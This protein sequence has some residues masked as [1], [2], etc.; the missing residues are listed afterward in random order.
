[1]VPVP[2][3]II[4]QIK[5]NLYGTGWTVRLTL[6]IN[7]MNQITP[8]KA[9]K[10]AFRKVKP[11][12]EA[13]EDFKK[14]LLECIEDI[15]EAESEEFHKTLVRD[16]LKNTYY[17][18]YFMNTKGRNDQVIHE[19]KSESTPVAVI[20][21]TKRPTNKS[22]MVSKD[23]L[24]AKAMQELLLYYL[25]E[26]IKHKNEHIK[27]LVI[28]N[29]YEWFIFD[30][31]VFDKYFYKN[32]KLLDD[33]KDFD[34]E[35]MSG[36]GTDYF[37]NNIAKPVIEDVKNGLEFTY[38]DIRD[39]RKL[40]KTEDSQD[41]AKLIP[42][43]KIFSPEHLLKLPFSNDSN[44][45]DRNFYEELLHIIGLKETKQ[46]SK[47]LIQRFP[48][49]E[50]N[51]GSLLEN[52]ITKL[53]NRDHLSQVENLPSYGSTREEQLFAV[54]LE[55][56]ITWIN[57][58]LFLK[59]LEAQLLSYHKQDP[60][61]KF[62]NIDRIS[63]YDELDNLFFAVLAKKHEER[64]DKNKRDFSHIPYLNS[65]LFE[66]AP[67][68]HKTIFV[69]DLRDD[70]TLPIISKTVFKTDK[71][72]KLKGELNVI[73]YLF[74]FLDAYDFSS[75]GAEDIQEE[76][77][78][79]INA[80]VLGLIFEKINGYKDGSYF[81]P[82]FIT[83][84]M[85]RETIRRAVVQKFNEAKDW[86]CK[87]INDIYDKIDDRKEANEIVNSL[88][89]CDPAVGSGHFL[90]SALNEILAIKHELKI[91]SDREGK[92]L[93]EYTVS[94]ENDE[95]IIMDDDD[96]LFEYNPKLPESQR[97]QETLFHEK[98]TI[99]ENCLFGVDI[100]PNSV[101]ICRLRLWIELLKNAYYKNETELE[102]LPNIDINIKCGNSL[103]S[104]F[105]IKADL[106]K[107]LKKSKFD[108][109][110]YRDAVHVYQNA[111]DKVQKR[112]MQDLINEIKSN[113]RT[114][115]YANDPKIKRM[116]KLQGEIFNLTNQQ[117]IFE[118]S[119]KE[120]TA[121]E[122]NITQLTADSRKLEA[123]IDE[124]KNN[125]IYENAFE[126]RFEFPEV[127]DNNGDFIG[128]DVIIGNPPYVD[129][130]S[131]DNNFVKF[132]FKDYTT[133]ENR[134][135]LYSLF[136]ELGYNI[137][138]HAGQFCFINPNSILMNSSYKKIRQLISPN[139]IEIIKLPDNIFAASSVKVE[140]I[141]LS[142]IKNEILKYAN[143][144]RYPHDTTITTI[145][146]ELIKTQKKEIWNFSGNKF[147][148]YLT[149][150]I[151][152]ILE[153][154]NTNSI[155]LKELAEF[156]LGITPYDKYTG[157]TPEQIKSRVFHATSKLGKDFRPL[158]SGSN[159]IQYYIDDKPTEFIKYGNWLGAPREE[160]FF[161]LPRVIVRQIVSGNPLRIFAG[162]T[163]KPLYFTQIGFSILSKDPK[164]LSPKFLTTLLN[165]SLMNFYHKYLYLDIEKELFQKILIENCKQFPIKLIT[166][167][168]Q[169]SLAKLAD[170]IIKQKE[171]NI[172]ANVS[173]TQSEIDQLVYE[174]YGL[175][176]KEIVI[177]EGN[178]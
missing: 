92:R 89:I 18:D 122:K 77:K 99:I 94:V 12:R 65:S 101:K 124:I 128:F 95:L 93:K 53:D 64:S 13:I 110:S 96:T 14:N 90:V 40:L 118:M 85:C 44:S 56:C 52:A 129:I 105:D 136:I 32:K 62:L 76:N 17:K 167:K 28:S 166:F 158:I 174:L 27:H 33:H 43:F 73:E 152:A 10:P 100:N 30:A 115:I 34:L 24:N 59:L 111:K 83:E 35:R 69:T 5:C 7:D 161:T 86:S 66:P 25:D 119:P 9:L 117:N 81:T 67:L 138:Y 127:L 156:C 57:R 42:L 153:K 120:K 51:P 75:E 134:M 16:F 133:T 144:I 19:G 125:K 91:L 97:V 79:L 108:I 135:N 173:S 80:S 130:K 63:N 126:W 29:I 103:I 112:K 72:K 172:D 148:L 131:L 140:T 147:N 116:Y 26:R 68:E 169:Q 48:K 143:I 121:W 6:G 177:V 162:Y 106:S 41:D 114:E 141:I 82:G 45:L 163:E 123:Q 104:R 78:T 168:E 155:Q 50:R 149:D 39:Y 142:F 150:Q 178:T 2:A 61:Y 8:R 170:K 175:T 46:G 160:R 159:V 171:Q 164:N 151:Y 21:E 36:K 84:Y 139:I 145:N 71:S 15:N 23:D 3:Q 60:A 132:L 11:H 157:H 176:E 113:F 37:Y 74:K 58:I 38:F 154:I 107:A 88:K 47:K 49:G 87:D 31:H 70:Q 55:L 20:I 1:M 22:E 98:Q 109:D 4:Q 137:L 146:K 165:S 102:T 54:G